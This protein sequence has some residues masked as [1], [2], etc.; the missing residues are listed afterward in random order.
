[1]RHERE[2]LDPEPGSSVD[3]EK[4]VHE[5]P[6]A[7][8]EPVS[9]PPEDLEHRLLDGVSCPPS[10]QRISEVGDPEAGIRG[11]GAAVGQLSFIPMADPDLP[12]PLQ[13]GP[14]RRDGPRGHRVETRRR[15]LPA[16]PH[17]FE[18]GPGDGIGQGTD[19]IA[20]SSRRNPLGQR[21]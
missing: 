2:A 19:A 10:C 16:L 17:L 20:I 4:G 3:G 13:E 15:R 9:V 18:Q 7:L 21:G 11:D 12:L 5:Q 14:E 8:R 6:F 1:M